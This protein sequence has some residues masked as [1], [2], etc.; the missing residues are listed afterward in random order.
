MDKEQSKDDLEKRQEL[1]RIKVYRHQLRKKYA[2]KIS[3]ER[4]SEIETI[5]RN[6]YKNKSPES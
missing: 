5:A 6:K 1:W 4:M 3:P 2:D